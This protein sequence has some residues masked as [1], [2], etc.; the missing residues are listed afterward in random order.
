MGNRFYKL[1]VQNIFECYYNVVNPASKVKRTDGSLIKSS[2]E[3]L[4]EWSKYFEKLYNAAPVDDDQDI[5]PASQN[6]NIEEGNFTSSELKAA[7]SRLNN[8]KAP[9]IDFSITAEAEAF[10]DHLSKHSC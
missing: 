1:S 3:L 2:K 10:M 5:P 8:Y 4:D 6:L 7:I 9:G